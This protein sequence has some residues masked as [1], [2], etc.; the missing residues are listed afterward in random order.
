MNIVK[1]TLLAPH[2]QQFKLDV[3]NGTFIAVSSCCFFFVMAVDSRHT[4]D[5]WCFETF[6]LLDLADEWLVRRIDVVKSCK[7]KV[8]SSRTA[9]QAVFTH[10]FVRL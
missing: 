4:A 10:R 6:F 9:D 3:T 5:V 2:N 7:E 8:Y 1:L